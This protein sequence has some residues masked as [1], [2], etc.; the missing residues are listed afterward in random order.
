MLAFALAI[1]IF[2]YWSLLGFSLVS[3]LNSQKN[4]LRNALLS[5]VVGVAAN[6]L[7]VVWLNV[8]GFPLKR[9]TL[10]LTIVLL[11]GAILLM[12]R[13]R[14]VLPI[15]QLAPFI[16]VLIL[17]ALLTGYP[18]LRFGFDWVS[19]SNDDMANYSLGAHYLSNYSFFLL[20][21]PER[22]IED[23][24]ASASLSGITSWAVANALV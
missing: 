18:L 6:L 14:P 19:F 13:S 15:K 9:V 3:V 24:D 20:P 7:F 21:P 8:I 10:A 5:P 23:R 2:A 11:I 1:G 17:G 4:L 12:V 22:L 16:V